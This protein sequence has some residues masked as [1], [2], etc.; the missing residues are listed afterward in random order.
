MGYLKLLY[1]V[2][3]HLWTT[4]FRQGILLDDLPFLDDF[5]K[6]F[7]KTLEPVFKKLFPEFLSGDKTSLDSHKAFVVHYSCDTSVDSDVDLASHF[8]NSEVTINIS[9][10]SGEDLFS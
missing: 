10:S 2:W 1:T 7:R 4:P 3:R 6:D 9:L 5:L 8:D